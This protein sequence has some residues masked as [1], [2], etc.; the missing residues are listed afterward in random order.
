MV[1]HGEYKDADWYGE[2]IGCWMKNHY[3]NKAL[4]LVIEFTNRRIFI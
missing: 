2:D 4:L 1:A 3:F